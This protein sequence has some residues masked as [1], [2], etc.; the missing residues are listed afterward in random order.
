VE[1][2]SCDFCRDEQNLRFGLVERVSSDEAQGLL[3]V[4]PNCRS[5][6]LDP[7]DG[8]SKPRLIDGVE[9]SRWMNWNP[10]R[11]LAAV[12]STLPRSRADSS[13]TFEWAELDGDRVLVIFR[14][15]KHGRFGVHYDLSEVPV[16]NNTGLLCAT[17]ED[18]AFEIVVTMDEQIDTGGVLRAER[19][20]R[21]DGLTVLR[22]VW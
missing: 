15:A 2:G 22:W 12:R 3:L 20:T 13:W 18:W 16:G 17:P 21:P 4:C 1:R 14:V 19:A 9:A 10:D 7:A 8:I 6:Y 11:V 5:L